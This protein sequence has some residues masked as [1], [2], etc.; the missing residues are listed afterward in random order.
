VPRR[1]C[2]RPAAHGV[3]LLQAAV[4]RGGAEGR[5][6]AA[7]DQKDNKV[8]KREYP[9]NFANLEGLSGWNPDCN[10]KNF[11]E[12]LLQH[13]DVYDGADPPLADRVVVEFLADRVRYCNTMSH[14]GATGRKNGFRGCEPMYKYGKND[15]CA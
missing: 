6:Q 8:G 13:G 12:F 9:R 2:R 15:L 7:F 5:P 11:R 10:A 3:C 4:Q 14:W 1:R